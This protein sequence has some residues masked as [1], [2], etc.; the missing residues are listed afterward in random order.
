MKRL[1][2][3]AVV[4]VLLVV[5]VL[6]LVCRR[7]STCPG[8]G[9]TAPTAGG[10]REKPASP[11]AQAA[12]DAL[13]QQAQAL[14]REGK[15]N[16][17]VNLLLEAVEQSKYETVQAR[18]FTLGQQV[19]CMAGRGEAAEK[20]FWDTLAKTP[21]VAAP[22]L[23]VLREALTRAGTNAFF[24][25]TQRLLDAPLPAPQAS[26]AYG[27]HL[28]ACLEQGDL[29]RVEELLPAGLD[30]FGDAACAGF[31]REVGGRLLT[32]QR[33][34]DLDRLLQRLEVKAA[35]TGEVVRAATDLRYDGLLARKD[36]DGAQAMF[37]RLAGTVN[38]QVASRLLARTA[39][40][41]FREGEYAMPDM[42]CLH[43]LT[44]CTNRTVLV[45]E[46]ARQWMRLLVETKQYAEVPARLTILRDR[47]KLPL[48]NLTS[49]CNAHF[50]DVMQTN[51][52]A[53]LRQ[54]VD[55][56][57]SLLNVATD[58]S[59]VEQLKVRV[60]DGCFVLED[61]AT[62]LKYVE[63]KIEGRTD[64]WHRMASAKMK[65]HMAL[66][67]GDTDAAVAHF[68]TFMAE[69]A[70]EQNLGEDPTTGIRYTREMCLGLNARRIG[71]I[72]VKAG[73]AVPS[74]AAYE[75]AI[76]FY[77]VAA[78]NTVESSR[79]YRFVTNQ[80]AAIPGWKPERLPVRQP[81]PA[82][83]VS[84]PAA[85][86]APPTEAATSNAPP[87][88]AVA[89]PAAPVQ[90]PAPPAT[91]APPADAAAPAVAAPQ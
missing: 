24:T 10:E 46:A 5:V 47:V 44:Q 28:T 58:K 30:R 70:K 16:E 78:T 35:A 42:L 18:V 4:V 90:T 53:A 65:A 41:G 87:A 9:G 8:P 37:E 54:M 72:L 82:P 1:V 89:P 20:R 34:G 11:E 14:W 43:V 66:Q 83:V 80:L 57:V 77:L 33:Y 22:S 63:A 45:Q 32:G 64:E 76:G 31:V 60:V 74:A 49:L 84:T 86:N 40:A 52:T 6:T 36:W 19:L 67:A 69:I 25:F 17:V 59:E 68:R 7:S 81:P 29:A 61:Y 15:T 48:A 13:V 91:N 56:G 38:E 55:L 39:A 88:E 27:W 21:A 75:E 23:P 50:Y 79:E 2:V 3:V 51:N 71:D 62:G 73:K 26:M 85:S 12:L